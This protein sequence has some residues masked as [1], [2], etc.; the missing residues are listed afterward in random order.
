MSRTPDKGGL[1]FTI[2]DQPSAI[3]DD[4]ERICSRLIHAGGLCAM[5][6][7]TQILRLF[8]FAGFSIEP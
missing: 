5:N 3:I 1:W 2:I 4:G 6:V 8:A 7:M